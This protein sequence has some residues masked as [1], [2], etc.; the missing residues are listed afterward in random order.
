FSVTKKAA[1]RSHSGQY[2][3]FF[4]VQKSPPYNIYPDERPKRVSKRAQHAGAL[5]TRMH[6]GGGFGGIKIDL[7]NEGFEIGV[8]VME[9]M[10]IQDRH[11]R[12][13]LHAFV[14]GDVLEPA[15]L[16]PE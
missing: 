11:G 8:R 9:K 5:A 2:K 13:R 7:G 3:A 10:T 12:R 4:S 15:F 6:H 14:N 1:S 16:A